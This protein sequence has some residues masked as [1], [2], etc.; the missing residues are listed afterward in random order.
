VKRGLY[1]DKVANVWCTL[2]AFVKLNQLLSKGNLVL[3]CSFAT[4]IACAP[5]CIAVAIA[6][7]SRLL[8]LSTAGCA[9]SAYLLSYQVHEKQILIP[10][11]PIALLAKDMP[12]T[13]LWASLTSTFSLFPLLDREG[14][15]L[16]YIALILGHAAI[17]DAV[18]DIS[19]S[20]AV[21][22][23]TACFALLIAAA[24]HAAKVVG[25]AIPSKPDL[26]VLL[27]TSFACVNFCML[28]VLL[29]YHTYTSIRSLPRT[30]KT[31]KA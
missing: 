23:I 27:I 11:M 10:L 3:L 15:R 12:A 14:L 22:K 28:Y 18:L 9:L 16:A 29:L 17:T 26:Y 30:S 20:S 25:P 6:P 8:V 31:H 1:E 24:L 4:V 21:E 7:T 19:A 13:A 2:S 5:F